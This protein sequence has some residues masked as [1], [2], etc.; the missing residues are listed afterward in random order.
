MNAE[1]KV[2]PLV[3]EKLPFDR[4]RELPGE[5]STTLRRAL[6]SPLEYYWHKKNER[7]DSDTLR[8][9]RAVHTATLEPLRF[10]KE[11]VLWEGGRRAGKIWE[12]F[13]VEHAGKTI[14]KPEQ[15][16]PAVAMSEAIRAH[17]VAGPLFSVS[18]KSEL[19]IQWR[20]ESGRLCKARIDRL[21][22]ALIDIKTA[23]DITPHGFSAAAQRYGYFAQMA[24]Y[25]DAVKAAGLGTFPVRIVAVQKKAPHDVAVYEIGD[26]ELAAGRADYERALSVIAECE[27]TGVW[28]GMAASEA[29]PLKLPAWAVGAALDEEPI[30][31]GSEVIQ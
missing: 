26:D 20:H 24:F 13:E 29:I 10:L 4:Y 18:G 8:I 22:T 5:H 12:A 2:Y 14:L 28:P 1:S 25:A 16:D 11:Y 3:I 9:G 27:K 23:H 19:T 17:A 21:G 15:Y 31:F 7:E 30:E 6:V